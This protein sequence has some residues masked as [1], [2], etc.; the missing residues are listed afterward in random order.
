QLRRLIINWACSIEDHGISQCPFPSDSFIHLREWNRQSHLCSWNRAVRTPKTPP[1][2]AWF[3]LER[4]SRDGQPRPARVRA[5]LQHSEDNVH[6]SIWFAG[7]TGT[8]GSESVRFIIM[9]SPGQGN[10]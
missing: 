5:Q 1:E 10:Y 7:I 8:V 4:D 2:N 3:L 6:H 9:S